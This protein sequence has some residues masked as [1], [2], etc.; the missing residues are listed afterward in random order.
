MKAF[1]GDE[2]VAAVLADY[3]TAPIDA[4]LRA[5][6]AFLEKLTL[7]PEALDERDAAALREA[8]VDAGA[9]ES[10]IYVAFVFNAMDGWPT[11]ST[12]ASTTRAGCAGWRA[13]SCA[14]ATPPAACPGER[15]SRRDAE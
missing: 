4:R 2:L 9:A 13:S 5:T 11:R 12:S 1:G 14:W 7:T 6:L 15:P 8:G 3:R 10:A